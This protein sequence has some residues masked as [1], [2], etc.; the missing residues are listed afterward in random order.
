MKA[1]VCTKYGPP[2]ALQLKE[3]DKATVKDNEGLIR[4]HAATVAAGELYRSEFHSL[5]RQVAAVVGGEKNR[6]AKIG[7]VLFPD[8]HGPRQR[9]ER[10]EQQD[11]LQRAPEQPD[12][13]RQGPAAHLQGVCLSHMLDHC[14]F[15]V[16]DG[17]AFPELLLV[18]VNTQ[19]GLDCGKELHAP[20][21]V[22][23]QV[24]A[25]TI[26]SADAVGGNTA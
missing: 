1:A 5:H 24:F 8:D 9:P 3:V 25:D 15:Q 21:R 23:V 7:N 4:I 10:R 20:Q 22:Q 2:D 19:V 26:V 18:D 11:G 16:R 17:C 6:P 13:E 14:A 12:R